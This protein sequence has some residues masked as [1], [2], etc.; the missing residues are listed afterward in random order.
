MNEPQTQ[1][2]SRLRPLVTSARILMGLAFLTFGFNGFFH[3]I[4]EPKNSMPAGAGAFLGALMNTGYMIPVIFG[5]QTLAGALLLINRFVP[6]ALALIA[7]VIV[8]I[9][10]FHVFLAPSGIPLAG[11]VLVSEVFLAWAYRKSYA[12]M[13]SAVA[14]PDFV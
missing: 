7:P 2:K 14:N 3:F 9:M 11:A 4:P 12:T 6:L 8:N 13:L 10:L 1:P 5:T